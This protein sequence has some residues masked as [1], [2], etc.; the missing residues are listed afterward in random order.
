MSSHYCSL[1]RGHRDGSVIGIVVRMQHVR[2]YVDVAT[3]VFRPKISVHLS[4]Q[5]SVETFYDCRFN[6]FV[7]VSVKFKLHRFN[8]D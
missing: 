5:G 6:I 8:M 3:V 2:Q 7:F 1:L 4:F